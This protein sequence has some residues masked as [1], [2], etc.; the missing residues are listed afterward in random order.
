MVL[1]LTAALWTAI[2]VALVFR[3]ASGATPPAPPHVIAWSVFADTYPHMLATTLLAT[4]AA[5]A[6]LIRLGRVTTWRLMLLAAVFGVIGLL[7][8]L[9]IQRWIWPPRISTGAVDIAFK[10]VVGAI[11]CFLNAGLFSLLAGVRRWP[12][13]S[14]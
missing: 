4:T 2:P 11:Y 5:A 12:A 7:I 1:L 3:A 9:P 10:V 8:W 14:V 13:R 6:V